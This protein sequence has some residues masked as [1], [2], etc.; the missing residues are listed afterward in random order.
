MM[1]R[2]WTSSLQ[3]DWPDLRRPKR[4]PARLHALL[5]V[6]VAAVVVVVVCRVSGSSYAHYKQRQFPPLPLTDRGR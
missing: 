2:R 3:K 1:R 4:T 5:V 6:V